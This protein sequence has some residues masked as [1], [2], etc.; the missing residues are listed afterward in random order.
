MSPEERRKLC[1]YYD[2]IKNPLGC[3]NPEPCQFGKMKRSEKGRKQ[4]TA[5]GKIGEGV[6]KW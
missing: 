2:Q 6:R 1:H 4:C 3:S 5:N